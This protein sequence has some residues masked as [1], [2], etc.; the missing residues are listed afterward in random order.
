MAYIDELNTIKNR[1][2]KV[3][4]SAPVHKSYCGVGGKNVPRKALVDALKFLGYNL[5]TTIHAHGI[6]NNN[7]NKVTKRID[8]GDG[9]EVDVIIGYFHY[10][11]SMYANACTYWFEDK[12][13]NTI[14]K[15]KDLEFYAKVYSGDGSW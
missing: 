9:Y 12:D 11:Y 14:Y 2:D 1:F 8:M 15:S 7:E 4:F 10:T 3:F 5:D 13:H 6:G